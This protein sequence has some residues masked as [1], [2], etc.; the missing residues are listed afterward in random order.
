MENS[1]TN[2]FYQVFGLIISTSIECP[3]LLSS[4]T[5]CAD[6]E[7]KIG[8]VPKQLNK[9]SK[10]DQN[11]QLNSE[12]L[13]L[14][15]ENVGSYLIEKGQKITIS[16]SELGIY[17]DTRLVLLG[18]ALGIIQHQR[19]RLTLHASALTNGKDTIL[20]CGNSGAGKS[21]TANILIKNGFKLLSDDLA[22]I[23]FKND[24]PWLMPA[25]PQSKLWQDA[26]DKLSIETQGLKR[27]LSN[28]D[29]FAYPLHQHFS[30]TP[31][32]VIHGLILGKADITEPKL[33]KLP[34]VSKIDLMKRH[35]YRKRLLSNTQKQTNIQ[36]CAKLASTLN[37]AALHRPLESN[38]LESVL[39]LIT[40]KFINRN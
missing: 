12:Q 6:V 13:L 24:Q 10:Q 35:T 20:I 1:Q 36:Q 3:E 4:H 21:T 30:N 23:D 22:V 31:T 25:Y 9:I 16:P 37:I 8:N 17:D 28:L 33:V 27:V 15:V 26:T 34:T 2:Y 5:E 19:G 40:N 39:D 18:S 32:K 14:K 29:K 7:I 11:Y 38:S